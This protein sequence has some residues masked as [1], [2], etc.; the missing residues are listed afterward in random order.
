MIE[1]QGDYLEG[2]GQIIRTS[3]GLSALTGKGFKIF[4]IRS[5]RENPGLKEQHLQA[6]R[7]IKKLCNAEVKGLEL[8]STELE[9][10]PGKI[11]KKKL[12]I[13]IR[14]AG[15]TALVLQALLIPAVKHS[16]RIDINGGA[17]FNLWA[18]SIPYMQNI[19]INILS[20]FGYNVNIEIKK[21]GFYP[22]GNA[23]VFARTK[24]AKELLAVSLEEQGK[25]IGI[26]GTSYASEDL[27]KS[28]VAER[29]KN[30]AIK[31][32]SELEYP[33]YIDVNYVNSICPGS[34]IFLKA[35]FEN[36]VLGYD[37]VGEKGKYSEKVGEEAA[38]GLIK[39]IESGATV[40]KFMTDQIL[41]YMALSG[42]DCRV[43]VREVTKHAQTN[44]WLIEK[45]LP[46]KFKVKGNIIESRS[47][48]KNKDG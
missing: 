37:V 23:R 44:I 39:E 21:H 48:G 12:N 31:L 13:D 19:L 24:E 30:A 41:P 46:V 3:S 6:I 4:N 16:L 26:S 18:P 34:G 14:T 38:K 43:K 40:D 15:S 11:T 33:I 47:L 1:V 28:Q 32:L 8:G 5:G 10:I 45:F 27:R 20:K 25:L 22:R 2:G 9:F 7:A 42:K 29:Q 35:D 17:T 36:C